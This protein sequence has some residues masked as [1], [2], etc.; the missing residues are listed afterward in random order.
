[1]YLSL[2]LSSIPPYPCPSPSPSLSLLLPI[3][4]FPL[5][6]RF[7][8]L[9]QSTISE[10]HTGRFHFEAESCADLQCYDAN[11]R[12]LPRILYKGN[13]RYVGKCD[14]ETAGGGWT[15]GKSISTS[16]RHK[17]IKVGCYRKTDLTDL[18]HLKDVTY[19]QLQQTIPA[20]WF[21]KN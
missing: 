19:L 21:S 9:S 18:T 8:H 10:F 3:N 16:V 6:P 15:V 2:A 20:L 7:T 5:S 14:L 17:T 13:S 12:G 1:M 11:S 4:Y